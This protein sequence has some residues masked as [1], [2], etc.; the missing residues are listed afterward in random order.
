MSFLAERLQM[1]VNRVDQL[2]LD[3][4]G[5]HATAAWALTGE[6]RRYLKG[7]G[8]LGGIRPNR[9]WGAI[10]LALRYDQLDLD[11]EDVLGGQEKNLTYGVN[12]YLGRNFRLMF[13]HVEAELDPNRNG[14]KEDVGITQLRAQVNF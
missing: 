2:S 5:W 9:K 11:D 13:D 1:R 3:F 10:E 4:S 14:I 12:W 7:S 8:V 6:S